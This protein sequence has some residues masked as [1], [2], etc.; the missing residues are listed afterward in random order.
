MTREL[1]H[2]HLGQYVLHRYIGRSSCAIP[3]LQ[4]DSEPLADDGTAEHALGSAFDRYGLE[5]ICHE[6]GGASPG[7]CHEVGLGH[8]GL[9]QLR[10]R[11]RLG[12]PSPASCQ[13]AQRHGPDRNA[14]PVDHRFL[15]RKV[16]T[17]GLLKGNCDVV[18]M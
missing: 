17:A 2:T 4:R 3:D 10:P 14:A 16:D 13:L 9:E 5:R 1:D 18:T 15:Q 12:Q 8:H 11:A 7:A 6:P